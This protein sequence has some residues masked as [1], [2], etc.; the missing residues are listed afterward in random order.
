M[1]SVA[2]GLDMRTERTASGSSFYMAMRILPRPKREAMFAIYAFFRDIDDIADEGNW[3]A[4][5]RRA[6]LDRWRANLDD[7]YDR[8]STPHFLA[9]ATAIRSFNLRKDDFLAAIDGVEMDVNDA[10]YAPEFALLDVYCD[11]VA[12]AVGRL[13]VRIFGLPESDGIALA[14]HLG[15]ALQLTNIL[16]DLDEDAAMGRL[17]LPRELLASAGIP[18]GRPSEVV[19]HGRIDEVC[20]D[21]AYRARRHYDAADRI[22]S[23][24]PRS[25]VVAPQLMRRV[26][27]RVLEKMEAIGWAWPRVRVRLGKAQL[28]WLALRGGLVR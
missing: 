19:A 21:L 16:R 17:Y 22:M 10:V 9:L 8:R 20:R 5:D 7:L 28:A 18:L 26:Y 27:G 25:T 1:A 24:Q 12:S 14:H 13:S 2:P 3:S 15:R 23:R 4:A 11:R 6:A